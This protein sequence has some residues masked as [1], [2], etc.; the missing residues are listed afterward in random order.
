MTM[1]HNAVET[2]TGRLEGGTGNPIYKPAAIVEYT[3]QMGGV[4]LS[5]Q[6]M[7][8]YNFLHRS[9]KWWREIVGPSIQYG[10]T[11]WSC[12]E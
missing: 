10:H 2:F 6:L 4:D 1:L 11:Q 9:C 8:Y 12:F 7:N 3:K 5:D